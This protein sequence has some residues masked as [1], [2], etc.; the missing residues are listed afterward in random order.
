MAMIAVACPSCQESMQIDTNESNTEWECPDCNAAFLVDGTHP[1]L[2]F[3][4]TEPGISVPD[5]RLQP[6]ALPPVVKKPEIQ[7]EAYVFAL[8]RLLKGAKPRDVRKNLVRQG[9]SSSDADHIIQ[10]AL[11]FQRDQ[12]AKE[13]QYPGG[14]GRSGQRNMVIGGII[15]PVGIVLTLGSCAAA[16]HSQGTSFYLA[17]G[18]IMFGFAQFM[19]GFVQS[20][21]T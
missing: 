15:C 11:K 8:E 13:R 5:I 1:N 6:G 7:D 16:T 12:E 2:N 4:I 18:A 19:R 9:F 17:W 3:V 14:G 10:T 20:K 21:Q